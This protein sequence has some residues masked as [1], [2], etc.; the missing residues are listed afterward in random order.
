MQKEALKEQGYKL[1]RPRSLILD[2]FAKTKKPV[3][4]QQIHQALQ[5]KIDKVTVYRVLEVLENIGLI[6]EEK[7]DKE[8]LY[9]AAL[10]EHHHIV[11]RSC[12]F[13]Q[14]LP[15]NHFFREVKNFSALKHQMFISGLCKKC[16]K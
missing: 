5:K 9:Y 2:F 14:C 12:G 7:G 10:K 6:F 4:A 3:S 16:S 15:C 8:K 11:C 1:T 13:S